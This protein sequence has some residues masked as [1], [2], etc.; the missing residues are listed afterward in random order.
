MLEVSG[1][2]VPADRVPADRPSELALVR[3]VTRKRLHAAPDAIT[4]FELRKRSIDAR[5]RS[6]VALTYT[7]RVTLAGG[8]NAERAL[9]SKLGRRH[10]DR[11][12]RMIAEER[13]HFPLRHPSP[14]EDRPVVV[15]AGCAGLFCAL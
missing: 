9:L 10:S 13:S 1:I 11:G 8:A 14:L 12:V 3:E 2:H 6:E 4:S 15:G 5:K 7:V